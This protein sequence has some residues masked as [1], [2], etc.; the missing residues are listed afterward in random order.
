VLVIGGECDP[1]S[2]GTRLEDLATA[3]RNAGNRCLQLKIY[4][5]ARHELFNDSNRDEVIQDVLAW[6]EQ[7]LKNQRPPK[8]E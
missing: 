4:P 5:Q 8:T 3:L 2:N 6:L 1:V 7:A